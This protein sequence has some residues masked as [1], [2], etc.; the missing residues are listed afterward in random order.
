MHKIIL[1]SAWVVLTVAAYGQKLKEKKQPAGA[2][3]KIYPEIKLPEG[4]NS[5]SVNMEFSEQGLRQD[6]VVAWESAVASYDGRLRNVKEGAHIQ[7]DVKVSKLKLQCAEGYDPAVPGSDII[8]ADLEAELMVM[9]SDGKSLVRM[10]IPYRVEHAGGVVNNA[11][12]PMELTVNF[13]LLRKLKKMSSEEAC[14]AMMD[15]VRSGGL[16][17]PE[18][19]Y[20]GIIYQVRDTLQSKLKIVN[21]EVAGGFYGFKKMDKLMAA[22]EAAADAVNATTA[23]S[24]KK[25]MPVEEVKSVLTKQIEIWRENLQTATSDE[26]KDY[27][28]Y[29]LAFAYFIMEDK[30]SAAEYLS[31]VQQETSVA[32]T[33]GS[34]KDDVSKLKEYLDTYGALAARMELDS[35]S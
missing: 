18:D 1:I 6:S 29:N 27:L 30:V 9:D 24:K 22:A 17:K 10:S 21:Y 3:F 19:F 35:N 8:T 26:M 34:F 33:M 15:E 13:L 32:I 12:K 25:R 5:V 14:K 4:A 16:Y 31:S 2:D 7:I 28:N 11:F 23:I 20:S